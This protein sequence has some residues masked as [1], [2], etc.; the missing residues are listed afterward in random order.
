MGLSY[1]ERFCIGDRASEY[2][3]IRAFYKISEVRSTIGHCQ[4]VILDEK[5]R[6]R[7]EDSLIS[8][9]KGGCTLWLEI[10]RLWV[11]WASNNNEFRTLKGTSKQ[12]KQT[13]SSDQ[14]EYYRSPSGGICGHNL[15]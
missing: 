15:K 5:G 14:T 13:W 2:K 3:V 8:L 12:S 9:I 11:L 6:E 10:R 1:R 7:N 4:S